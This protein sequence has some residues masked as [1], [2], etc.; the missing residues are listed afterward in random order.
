MAIQAEFD[1][2]FASGTMVSDDGE[3]VGWVQSGVLQRKVAGK[4]DWQSRLRGKSKEGWNTELVRW[5]GGKE[6]AVE[7]CRTEHKGC[8]G[9]LVPASAG[10]GGELKG[11]SGAGVKVVV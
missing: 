4:T 11:L 3:V 5:E 7:L 1:W 9:G 8:S 10:G 2:R 6:A